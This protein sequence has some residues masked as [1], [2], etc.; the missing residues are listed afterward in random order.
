MRV[1]RLSGSEGGGILCD[2]PYPYSDSDGHFAN[3]S[4]RIWKCT[5]I[6]LAPLPPSFCQGVWSPFR[7]PQPA[8]L[9]AGIGISFVRNDNLRISSLKV[10]CLS[11]HPDAGFRSRGAGNH[12]TDVIAIDGDHTSRLL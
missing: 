12:A 9:P 3:G 7:H 4:G 6:G 10:I 2:S 11:D 8:A 5:T 1:T